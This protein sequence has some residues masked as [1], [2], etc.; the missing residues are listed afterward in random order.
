MKDKTK[1]D[2]PHLECL[3]CDHTI[4]LPKRIVDI[5]KYSGHIR[6][7]NCWSL[8]SIKKVGNEIREYRFIKEG[9]R[10]IEFIKIVSAVPRPDYS[11]SDQEKA[12]T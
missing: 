1:A 2:L 8:L 5:E 7:K 9:K 3:H 4:K 10:P 6:C 11:K 12:Q